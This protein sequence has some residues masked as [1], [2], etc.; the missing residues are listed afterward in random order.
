MG[1]SL[2][3]SA[4]AAGLGQAG[5]NMVGGL[6]RGQQAAMDYGLKKDRFA[7]YEA[8]TLLGMYDKVNDP[9]QFTQ[10]WNTWIQKRGLEWP[11]LQFN[12]KTKDGDTFTTGD[13]RMWI[14]RPGEPPVD[15]TPGGQRKRIR[16]RETYERETEAHKRR[17][18]EREFDIQSQSIE[19]R[20]GEIANRKKALEIA[21]K[22]NELGM[23]ISGET[24]Q[25][26]I[27]S[28]QDYYWLKNHAPEDLTPEEEVLYQRMER[29]LEAYWKK[30]DGILENED[31]GTGTHDSSK[32]SL[33]DVW[34][35]TADMTHAAEG[36]LAAAAQGSRVSGE[37][38]PKRKADPLGIREPTRYTYEGGKLKRV[39]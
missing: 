27:G 19:A 20:K 37:G 15:I 29:F 34:K 2:K 25:F 4:L 10:I 5:S 36:G 11:S 26:L 32:A 16:E 12:K 21:E 39:Q 31:P 1:I 35:K 18:Q 13:G 17:M 38:P 30:Q 24:L 33:F 9:E 6:V 23:E 8:Q 3:G 14:K 22:Q 7:L 28:V